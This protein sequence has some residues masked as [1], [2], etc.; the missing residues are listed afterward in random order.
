MHVHY[1]NQNLNRADL[2]NVR[3]NHLSDHFCTNQLDNPIQTESDLVAHLDITL[4]ALTDAKCLLECNEKAA[5]INN[6]QKFVDS[7]AVENLCFDP[8]M[9]KDNLHNA[10]RKD[11][12]MGAQLCPMETTSSSDFI[13]PKSHRR[14]ISL[15]AFHCSK[16]KYS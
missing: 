11:I 7:A 2:S 15:P 6:M 16:V 5:S 13:Q 12:Q 10:Q 3:N 9:L 4:D 14:S 8:T 1:H